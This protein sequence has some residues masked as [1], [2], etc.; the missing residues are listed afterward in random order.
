MTKAQ[1]HTAMKRPFRCAAAGGLAASA[2]QLVDIAF[3]HGCSSERHAQRAL[4]VCQAPLQGLTQLAKFCCPILY[5]HV[6]MLYNIQKNKK[7]E[8]KIK[9]L[10]KNVLEGSSESHDRAELKGWL[11]TV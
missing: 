2:C 1:H 6:Y 9:G 7:Q 4:H 10:T 8:K 3:D 11:S 5:M